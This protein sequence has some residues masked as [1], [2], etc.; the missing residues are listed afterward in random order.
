[1]E[2]RN[3]HSRKEGIPCRLLKCSIWGIPLKILQDFVELEQ[4]GHYFPGVAQVE[5]SI[6]HIYLI[7]ISHLVFLGKHCAFLVALL[8]ALNLFLFTIVESDGSHSFLFLHCNGINFSK[9]F[10]NTFSSDAATE[11]LLCVK[12]KMIMRLKSHEF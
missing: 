12:Q 7:I 8:F 5:P 6:K 2:G 9:A 11:Y 10:L 1:M 4:V 3:R